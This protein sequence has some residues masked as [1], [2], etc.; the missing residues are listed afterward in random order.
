[1]HFNHSF[2]KV[3]LGTGDSVLNPTGY[4]ADQTALGGDLTVDLLDTYGQRGFEFVDPNS[5]TTIGATAPANGEPLILVGTSLM[6]N[7]KIGPFHG[8]YHETN[9]SK[10]INPKYV[11]HVYRVDSAVPTNAIV[12]IG[13]TSVTEGSC[14]CPQFYC[15][16]TYY[17]RID[18]KGSPI[19]RQLNRQS[20]KTVDAYTGCCS[21]A[22]PELSDPVLVMRSWAEQIVDTPEFYGV[23]GQHDQKMIR[24]S[25]EATIDGGTTW[26]LYVQPGLSAAEQAAMLADAAAAGSTAAGVAT[27]DT[28]VSAFDPASSPEDTCAGLVLEGAYVETEFA[29]CTFQVT[30][31]FE[32]Q[33]VKI[34]ASMVDETGNPCEFA[35]ICVTKTQ[36]GVQG[37]GFGERV[38]RDVILSESYRQNF[39]HTKDLRVR[40]ITQ[41][42][43]ILGSVDRSAMYTAY[44]IVHSVPR[45]I[46]PSG[47]YDA[48]KY[49]LVIYTSAANA[50]LETFL[51]D[52][53]TGAG[54]PLGPDITANGFTAY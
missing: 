16:E 52:W 54:N 43:E 19:L 12:H 13:Q 24:V 34:Y 23:Y 4:I 31:F 10:I 2:R 30:D 47:V 37:M 51:E 33:P 18:L 53:L 44:H 15:D 11:Q 50:T 20:Y 1:M 21:G 35:S 40:E 27:W 41:G 7:D 3:F 49:D 29:D 17:L 46:N 28:Y 48:D 38:V 9:K 45:P 39:T 22:V 42:T 5:W 25:F 26:T 6:S 8:G 32:V 14:P 36:E